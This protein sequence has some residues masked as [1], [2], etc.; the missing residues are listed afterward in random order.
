MRRKKTGYILLGLLVITGLAGTTSGSISGK[1]RKSAV[2]LMK[3]TRT[4][5]LKSIKDLSATQVNFKTTGEQWSVKECVYH[6]AASENKMWQWLEASL[7]QPANPEKRAE[8]KLTDE[9]VINLMQERAYKGETNES[10]EFLHV[11]F[12][13]KSLEEA[14]A[15]FKQKR[16]EHIEYIKSTTED[17]RNHVVQ[18]PLGWIDC[19][20][21]CLLISSSTKHYLQQIEE[22]KADPNF[23]AR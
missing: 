9:E 20:Q 4:D 6:I 22:L 21:V 8:I 15:D 13:Y 3:N 17:L 23:P 11:T 1:E 7:K 12:N 2:G 18:T 10:P 19:Y 14:I 16:A 5:V